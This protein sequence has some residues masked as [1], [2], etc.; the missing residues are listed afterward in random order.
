MIYVSAPGAKS[1]LKNRRAHI[2][3]NSAAFFLKHIFMIYETIWGKYF[4]NRFF[5]CSTCGGF[6]SIQFSSRPVK[7]S[8]FHKCSTH[9]F[10]EVNENILQNDF[11]FLSLLPSAPDKYSSHSL[12]FFFASNVLVCGKPRKHVKAIFKEQTYVG[13]SF[14]RLSTPVFVVV[15]H[16]LISSTSCPLVAFFCLFFSL[17]TTF[18]LRPLFHSPT[19]P[20]TANSTKNQPLKGSQMGNWFAMIFFEFD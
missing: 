17:I 2:D 1:S 16:D 11:F 12:S 13:I 19:S 20:F 6:I 5:L 14:N 4:D 7:D 9:N 8:M 18:S 15:K 3:M 10:F